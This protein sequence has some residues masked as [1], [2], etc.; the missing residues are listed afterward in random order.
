MSQGTQGQFKVAVLGRAHKDYHEARA[1]MEAMAT[2]MKQAGL[3][4]SPVLAA[5]TV[6]DECDQAVI[7]TYGKIVL[8]GHA[9]IK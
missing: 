1:A 9:A 6:L 4:S 8:D 5:I 7:T 3:D 2:H